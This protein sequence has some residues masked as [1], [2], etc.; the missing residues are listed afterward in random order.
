MQNHGGY[1]VDWR[2]LDK[3]VW[4][5]GDME[6]KYESVDMYLSLARESDNAF[7]ELVEYF[8]NQD[9]PTIIIMF[10][11]H[12]PG[13]ADTFYTDVFGQRK[14]TLTQAESVCLYQVPYVI[15]ANYDIEEKE[16]GDFSLNYLSTVFVDVLDYPKTGY[17]KFLLETMKELPV[18][19][20]NFYRDASGKWQGNAELLSATARRLLN[21][22]S[23]LQYNG[24]EGGKE[25]HDSFFN[26]KNND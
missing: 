4:L 17:Q 19:T 1:S 26:L 24:L 6:G 2:N 22:Y 25:R 12:H 23:I 16:Y 15:W 14:D 18:V 13:L 21:E 10:G 8:Q 11:D 3:T 9:E 7:K 5:T 20:R